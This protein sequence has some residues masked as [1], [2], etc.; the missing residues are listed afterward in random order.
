MPELFLQLLRFFALHVLHH[1]FQ[2]VVDAVIAGF[3]L[4]DGLQRFFVRFLVA[5]VC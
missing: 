5:V 1:F 3:R 2:T 4:A